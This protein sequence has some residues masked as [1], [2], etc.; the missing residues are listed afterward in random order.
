MNTHIAVVLVVI[1]FI[2]VF[3]G[4]AA[5]LLGPPILDGMNTEIAAVVVVIVSCGVFGGYVAY[6]FGPPVPDDL[7]HEKRRWLLKRAILLGVIAALLVPLFLTF[8]GVAAGVDTQLV[9]RLLGDK[10]SLNSW[11]ILAG[12]CLVA[13]VSSQR[14][15]S[16]VTDI[17]LKQL[18]QEVK[19]AKDE[20]KE[21]KD[22]VKEARTEAQ[23]T[24]K[25][26]E[27]EING[28]EEDAAAEITETGERVATVAKDMLSESAKQVLL[29][30]D[31]IPIRRPSP[32]AIAQ[33]TGFE[34]NEVRQ[35][36]E[37]LERN[38]LVQRR[39]D[40]PDGTQRWR[41]RTRGKAL[42]GK[43]Q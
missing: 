15:V 35:G 6:L 33:A 2:G 37:E 17:L 27:E 13:A 38:K 12:L 43:S 10:S 23:Q 32:E 7:S 3:G 39:D 19:E 20:V 4:F 42:L 8:I 21:A 18:Q 30:M 9:D 1:L 29:A 26:L 14:F 34:I 24:R 36:L 41:I 28:L 25:E 5:Y 22:E 11:L 40:A 16:A 31:R